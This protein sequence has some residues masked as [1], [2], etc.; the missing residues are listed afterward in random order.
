MRSTWPRRRSQ[1]AACAGRCGAVQSARNSQ[2]IKPECRIH[3]LGPPYLRNAS[4]ASIAARQH[5]SRGLSHRRWTSSSWTYRYLI[6]SRIDEVTER[7]AA[8]TAKR[9]HGGGGGG[10]H[11]N[12]TI[13]NININ[14]NINIKHHQQDQHR[15]EHFF[16]TCQNRIVYTPLRKSWKY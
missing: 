8:L 15:I 4:Y 12:N 1:H 6:E 16:A 13:I 3:E 2:K 10:G 9:G 5:S 14:I 11:N 7:R